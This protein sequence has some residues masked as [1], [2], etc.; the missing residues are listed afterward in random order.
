MDEPKNPG[1]G[2]KFIT[3]NDQDAGDETCAPGSPGRAPGPLF[4]LLGSGYYSPCTPGAW[5]RADSCSHGIRRAVPGHQPVLPARGRRSGRSGCS[6]HTCTRCYTGP[7]DHGNPWRCGGGRFWCDHHFRA[8]SDRCRPDRHLHSGRYTICTTSAGQRPGPLTS[9]GDRH[10]LFARGAHT[11]NS[12][13][14]TEPHPAAAITPGYD[15]DNTGHATA[16]EYHSSDYHPNP[17]SY[18]RDLLLR[19]TGL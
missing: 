9:T 2:K 11:G 3:A 12:P 14:Y 17:E 5:Y 4:R 18:V 16:P 15:P 8:C 1:A 13:G 7:D 19:K 6:V 10:G